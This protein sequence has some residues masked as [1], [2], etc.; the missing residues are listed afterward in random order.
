MTATRQTV[1]VQRAERAELESAAQTLR[2]H[3]GE[4]L[5]VI[6]N[7]GATLVLPPVVTEALHQI[8]DYLAVGD[9]TIGQFDGYTPDEAARILGA[10]RSY[11]AGVLERGE[12]PYRL[13]DAQVRIAH[14]DLVAHR[15]KLRAL[16]SEG[17]RLIQK[18]SEEEGAYDR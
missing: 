7:D 14:A 5:R 13:H 18:I 17:V 6:L 11:V 8:V 16:M 9:V 3:D 2:E 15:A 4:S 12:L 1:I 10:S